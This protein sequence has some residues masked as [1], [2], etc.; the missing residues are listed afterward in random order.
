MGIHHEKLSDIVILQSLHAL[1]AFS[2]AVLAL[3]VVHGHTLDVAEFGHGNHH[4]LIRDQILSG[5]IKL[6]KTDRGSSLVAVLVSNLGDLLADY[7]EQQV[8][9]CQDRFQLADALHELGVFVF[10][11]LPFQTG[12]RTETHIHD[13]LGLGI[14]ESKALHQSRFRRLS[15]GGTADDLNDLIDIVKGNEQSL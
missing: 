8:L 5:N 9:V 3:E 10:Q 13:S 14:R 2:A 11:L 7:A 1:D 12:Q 15:I 4:V 6:V